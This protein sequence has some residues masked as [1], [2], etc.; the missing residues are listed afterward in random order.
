MTRSVR[1]LRMVEV[2]PVGGYISSIFVTPYTLTCPVISVDYRNVE[3]G[4]GTSPYKYI[5]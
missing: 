2:C 1:P 5:K 3:R 4:E